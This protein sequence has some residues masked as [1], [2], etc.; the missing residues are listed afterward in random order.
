LALLAIRNGQDEIAGVLLAFSTVKPNIVI[1]LLFY[2]FLWALFKHRTKIIF[3]FSGAIVLLVGFSLLLIP[4][5]LIQ[6]LHEILR[7][8]TY[9]PPG[10]PGA[11]MVSQWGAIGTRFSIGLTII[12]SLILIFE[13]W[14]GRNC[15]FK[16]FLWTVMVTMVISQWIGIQTDPGNFILLLPAL[17]IGFEFLWE[18]WKERAFA[19]IITVLTLLFIGIWVLFLTTL[20]QDYQPIQN[21]LLFFPFPFV[22]L[23]LLYW[24][25]WWVIRSIKIKNEEQK[26][27]IF[28][29]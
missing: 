19:P 8:P 13:W 25:R 16:Q 29:Q 7:Y 22:V 20:N 1:L 28:S 11:A 10:S 4:D 24:S 15:V 18:R 14:K 3:W 5:W 6:N 21:S 12:L 9:S 17:F 2:I 23:T 26:I 27:G